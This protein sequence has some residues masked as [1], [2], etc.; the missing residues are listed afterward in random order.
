MST[1]LT[2]EEK[3]IFSTPNFL[4][5]IGFCKYNPMIVDEKILEFIK[6][7]NSKKILTKEIFNIKN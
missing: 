1:I 3:E 4:R 2:K 5:V 7:V 6:N